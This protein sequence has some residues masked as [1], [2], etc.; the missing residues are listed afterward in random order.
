MH[1]LVEVKIWKCN[2]YFEEGIEQLVRYLENEEKSDGH[3][4]ILFEGHLKKSGKKKLF[5]LLKS[6]FCV[7]QMLS[8]YFLCYFFYI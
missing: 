6:C 4:L 1:M 2:K 7:I 3:H 5:A 8:Y